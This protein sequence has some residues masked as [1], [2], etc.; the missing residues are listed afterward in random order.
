MP[1]PKP[2]KKFKLPENKLDVPVSVLAPIFITAV[3]LIAVL[4]YAAPNLYARL[5]EPTFENARFLASYK[6]QLLSY[7]THD[8]LK[9][10][11]VNSSASTIS[12]PR[13]AEPL[14]M[15]LE[16]LQKA[17]KTSCCWHC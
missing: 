3:V 6:D 15:P 13:L 14:Q 1:P 7:G 2:K 11:Q 17:S 5:A 9:S 8:Q 10:I 16:Y 4:A 12:H